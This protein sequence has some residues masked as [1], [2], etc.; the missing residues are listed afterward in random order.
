MSRY[1]SWFRIWLSNR[2]EVAKMLDEKIT[3]SAC[4]IV[5]N[6]EVEIEQW[7]KNMQ[8]C[9]DEQIVVDTGS[10]DR[11]VEIAKTYGVKIYH[12]IWQNDFAA[13][14]NF[15]IEQAN[16][17]WIIFLDA[18]EQFNTTSVANVRSVIKKKNEKLEA[19]DAIMC[20]IINID[21]DQHNIELGRFLNVRLFRNSPEL[22]YVGRIHEEIRHKN[23]ELQ[24]AIEAEVLEIYH[25]GYSMERVQ[26]K[27][28]RN[29]K[30]L[31]AEIKE[32]GESDKHYRYLSDCYHALGKNKQ[33]IKYAKL[34]LKSNSKSVGSESDVYRNLINSMIF[35]KQDEKA[36]ELYIKE[37]IKK[38]SDIPD[39]YAYYAASFFRKG[40]FIKAKQYF[41]KSLD[42]FGSSQL[43][44]NI[45]SSF[46]FIL[47]EVY[48]YLGQIFQKEQ[49]FPTAFYYVDLALKKNKYNC[50]AFEQ[51]YYLCEVHFYEKFEVCLRA[52]YLDS[53][54]D[55]NFIVQQLGDLDLCSTYF[56]YADL[57]EQKYGIVSVKT[58]SYQLLEKK[59]AA[60]FLTFILKK[61][62]ADLSTMVCI[63]LDLNDDEK[64]KK[65]KDILPVNFVY[66]LERYFNND[67]CLR[68]IDLFAYK[69]ILMQTIAYGKKTFIEK[70][71]L[72]GQEFSK[73]NL[74]DI[75]KDEIYAIEKS[76]VKN[77]LLEQYIN[78]LIKN[79]YDESALI[80]LYN[81]L[82]YE[83][84]VDVLQILR[85]LYQDTRQDLEFIVSRL[86]RYSFD[87]VYLY[88]ANLLKKIDK[89]KGEDLSVQ[90]LI[91]SGRRNQAFDFLMKELEID[92]I[93]M[94]VGKIIYGDTDEGFSIDKYLPDLY[95]RV[96]AAY[97]EKKACTL[98]RE[99]II[100]DHLSRELKK[101]K[102]ILG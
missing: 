54:D 17:D 22:R 14:K 102:I 18:D 6:E 50:Q 101:A 66:C 79:R 7:I 100:Y 21:K 39:F 73:E 86:K 10:T 60:G 20:T 30:L 52:Y 51:L 31:Q 56:Y 69:N 82:R 25:T 29:L 95:A 83:D 59:D 40:S 11:T 8:L 13:A 68:E 63:L 5:K 38:F 24:L 44:S 33:A 58:K 90:G 96:L 4:V 57:L 19:V 45:A 84:P 70:M 61:S 15:A 43:N 71:I 16:G 42:I 32:N 64:T 2:A 88:Y 78:L 27:I 26:N 35:L 98:D 77:S 65:G 3:I 99:K 53:K 67:L 87:K 76:N 47:A 97:L 93:L 36:I 85:A 9:S 41:L 12:Y 23:R 75:A 81:F 89:S 62:L 1:L 72:I 91:V 80:G 55:L 94:M 49:D 48:S 74:M 28:K 92:Y 37:A 46:M 34:H